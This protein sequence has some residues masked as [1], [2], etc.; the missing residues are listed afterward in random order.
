MAWFSGPKDRIVSMRNINNIRVYYQGNGAW[1]ESFETA[2]RFTLSDAQQFEKGVIG[3]DVKIR[4]V[5]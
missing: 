5:S 4:K 1:S 2:H 3:S